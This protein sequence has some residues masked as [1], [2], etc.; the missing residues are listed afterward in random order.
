MYIIAINHG[1]F[2]MK[3][4]EPYYLGWQNPAWDEDG[5][6]WTSKD[7]IYE[8]VKDRNNTKEHPFLFESEEQAKNFA[9]DIQLIN[10]VVVEWK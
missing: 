4:E 9:E 5:Y 2:G 1:I 10:Y 8:I 3:S 7:V 6:F